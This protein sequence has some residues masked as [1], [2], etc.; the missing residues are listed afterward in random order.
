[1]RCDIVCTSSKGFHSRS[2][3][4]LDPFNR[5][6]IVGCGFAGLNVARAIM[7]MQVDL[8]VVDYRNFHLFQP[9]LYQVATGGLSPAD[10]STPIRSL[11]DKDVR[12]ILGKASEVKVADRT[13]IL[14]DGE[15]LIYDT[16]VLA[17]GSRTHYYGKGE[18]AAAAPG[19]K[20]VEEATEI[21]RRILIAF[22]TAARVATFEKQRPWLTFAVVGGGPTGVELAGAIGELARS[23]LNKDFHTFD[24]A[25]TAILL[26]EG[27][28]EI[29][30]SFGGR[31]RDTAARALGRVGVTV[32]TGCQVEHIDELGLT[33]NSSGVIRHVPAKTVIWAAG[34]RASPV[35][36]LLGKSVKAELTQSGQ[37]VVEPDLT[38]PGHPEIF[39]A[40]DLASHSHQT[41]SPLRGT[42]D[43][44]IAEGKYI[45]QVIR[46]QLAGKAI[47]PFRFRPRG[48]LAVI[49]RS[50]AVA[51]VGPLR[52][53]GRLAWLIWLFV[54]LLNLV[55]FE[56][57]VLVA[58]QWGWNYLTRNRS[59]RLIT[60]TYLSHRH[61]AE[62]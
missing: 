34:V 42:A 16:L 43:V 58:I 12:V 36:E 30:P 23:T 56:N 54:H 26:F 20:T 7:G 51:E 49:G 37:L 24:L 21:R 25:E 47:H 4:A 17:T 3:L 14:S 52:L 22:E 15:E 41:G 27:G 2:K 31:Q 29:L 38:L 60:Q 35:G 8:T 6:V 32:R 11:L 33:V 1:M 55:G 53:E 28:P 5:V 13:V 9:L 10:I 45:G 48:Q 18:W 19:L 59:A 61:G 44:A 57:R 40:G 46:R 62:H 50:S 39:V